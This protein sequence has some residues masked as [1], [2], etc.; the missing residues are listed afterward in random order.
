MGVFL[1]GT[2]D[3]NNSAIGDGLA[4]C[5]GYLLLF[6][7]GNGLDGCGKVPKLLAER[8]APNLFVLGVLQ[9]MAI[10]QEV[11]CLVIQYR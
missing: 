3:T 11:T 7:E 1:L 8:F 6:N 9:Q 4:L 2:I 10:L 5:L